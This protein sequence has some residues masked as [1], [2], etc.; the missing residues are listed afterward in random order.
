MLTLWR[1][2]S[3]LLYNIDYGGFG[4]GETHSITRLTL[5]RHGCRSDPRYRRTLNRL[6]NGAAS[7]PM[8]WWSAPSPGHSGLYIWR[9]S[10][11][12]KGLGCD[13]IEQL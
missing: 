5:L 8:D 9:Q 10:K 11:E 4:V 6:C 13:N 2:R 1:C 7:Q 3:D 12:T